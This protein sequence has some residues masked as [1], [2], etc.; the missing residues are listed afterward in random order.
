MN[1]EQFLDKVDKFY[2]ENEFE[3][4]HGQSIMNV[5]H[6]IRKDLYEKITNTDLDCFYDDGTVQF[7][8]EY[9]EKAWED[10]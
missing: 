7:T 6:L 5:L 1:F 9:L 3:L 4:R 10:A 2:Y 8:L